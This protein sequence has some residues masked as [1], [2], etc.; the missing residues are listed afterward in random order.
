MEAALAS[1]EGHARG[2][3]RRR[4]HI[5]QM[6]ADVKPDQPFLRAALESARMVCQRDDEL[7]RQMRAA[8]VG[9]LGL[10]Q[11]NALPIEVDLRQ[12]ERQDYLVNDSKFSMRKRSRRPR[13]RLAYGPFGM[14]SEA[15]VNGFGLCRQK[16]RFKS[17]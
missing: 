6:A 2:L 4:K 5:A 1:R 12:G 8:R 14:G 17:A 7:W 15:A 10:G 16:P 3:H 9:V 11:I 13:R